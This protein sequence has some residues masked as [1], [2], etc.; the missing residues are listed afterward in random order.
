MI[1]FMA[2]KPAINAVVLNKPPHH[3]R[4]PAVG[5][6]RLVFS[7]AFSTIASL[8]AG[9]RLILDTLHVIH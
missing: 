9:R 3:G 1:V 8:A 4:R 2:I 5:K 6:A 7:S